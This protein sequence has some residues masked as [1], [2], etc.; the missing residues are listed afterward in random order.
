VLNDA[1]S[2]DVA[3]PVDDEMTMLLDAEDSGRQT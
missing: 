3:V 2:T 1:I